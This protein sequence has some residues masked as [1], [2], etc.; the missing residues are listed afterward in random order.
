MSIL[1]R[2]VDAVIRL[3]ILERKIRK[4]EE[5]NKKVELDKA[6]ETSYSRRILIVCFT[7]LLIGMLF[8]YIKL[9]KPWFNAF[10]A[11]AAFLLSTFTIPAFR[12]LWLE[13]I[14][15]R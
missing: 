11:A 1:R 12:K 14:Y 15:K 10:I 3:K 13:Y 2:Q 6:W 4:I 5:R 9:E 8:V 7:Y